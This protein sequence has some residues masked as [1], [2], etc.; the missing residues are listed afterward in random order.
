M[1]GY[2][3]ALI[4]VNGSQEVL[5]KGLRLAG[6][7]RCW[8]TVVKVVPE[9][10]GDLELVGV[11]NIGDVL[12]DGTHEL[13]AVRATVAAERSL[14]KVRL[15]RGDPAQR[16]LEAAE[17]ERCDVIVV[18]R[19]RGGWVRRLLGDRVVERVVRDAPC[20]VLVVDT[21]AA[22]AATPIG[23]PSHSVALGAA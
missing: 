23:I 17:E 4:A 21:G 6:D 19:P 9:N 8:V 18:G 7:E 14:A 10:E 1:R 5:R 12:G 3:K 2:R 11:R 13:A 20:P 22:A 16:I 15:E